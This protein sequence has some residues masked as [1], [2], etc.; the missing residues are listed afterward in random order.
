VVWLR[1]IGQF[2]R[3]MFLRNVMLK[4]LAIFIA[5]GLWFFVNAAQRDSE[6]DIAIPVRYIDPPERLMLISPRVPE[7]E[8]RVVGPPTLLSRIDPASLGVTI[9]LTRVRAGV[10]T[11]RLRSDRVDL[12]R[13]VTAIRMTPSELTLE[14]AKVQ[15]KRLPVEL[16]IE[17][18]PAGDLRIAETKVSPELVEVRGPAR[19]VNELKEAK[20]VAVDLSQAKAGRMTREIDIDIKGEFLTLS[21]PSVNVE[22]LLEEPVE[23]RKI[24]DIVIV[25]RNA[26]GDATVEPAEIALLVRGARSK[27]QGLELPNG[28]VYVDATGLAP[29]KHDALPLATLPAGIELVK[30]LPKVKVEIVERPITE[31]PGVLMTPAQSQAQ[32]SLSDEPVPAGEGGDA[33]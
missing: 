17:G 7:V 20:T 22:L 11:F 19:I 32:S 9:D 30:E 6:A 16:A 21:A 13:G 33:G 3:G 15:S 29:G 10:T 25:V 5:C 1:R 4:V 24:G 23:E 31:T 18:R 8:L 2:V 12:P 27:V 14:L 28:A 26:E